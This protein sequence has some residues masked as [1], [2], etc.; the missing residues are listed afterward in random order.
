MLIQKFD[1]AHFLK[2]HAVFPTILIQIQESSEQQRPLHIT[3]VDFITAL[4][5]L[6]REGL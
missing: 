1:K 3:F 4:D 6:S 5:V 2:I